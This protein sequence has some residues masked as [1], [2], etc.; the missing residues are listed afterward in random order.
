[1]SQYGM[2][3]SKIQIYIYISSTVYHYSEVKG[4]NTSAL[5]SSNPEPFSLA[6]TI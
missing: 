6:K 2:L 4:A 1:M 3:M 5:I